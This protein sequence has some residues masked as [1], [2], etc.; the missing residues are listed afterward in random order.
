MTRPRSESTMAIWLVCIGIS[1]LFLARGAF[2]PY[3]FPMF[4]HLEGLSYT[5]QT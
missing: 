4:E 1:F 3:I 2:Q 5:L